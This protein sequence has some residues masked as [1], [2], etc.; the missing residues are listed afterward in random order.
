LFRKSL[1]DIHR[2]LNENKNVFKQSALSTE[3]LRA[4]YSLH[5][6]AESFLGYMQSN[7]KD[8]VFGDIDAASI[9]QKTFEFDD[10]IKNS[11]AYIRVSAIR[12]DKGKSVPQR[13]QGDEDLIDLGVVLVDLSESVENHAAD[14]RKESSRDLDVLITPMDTPNVEP[15]APQPCLE[16]SDPIAVDNASNA[17]S[18]AETKDSNVQIEIVRSGHDK[19]LRRHHSQLIPVTVSLQEINESTQRV[20]AANISSSLPS[21]NDK[22]VRVHN[23]SKDTLGGH[24]NL[25]SR[26]DDCQPR[27]SHSDET[28]EHP[29]TKIPNPQE[30][31]DSQ[32]NSQPKASSNTIP[33]NKDGMA[34]FPHTFE[35]WEALSAHWKGLT[36]FWVR[37]L[38]ANAALIDSQPFTVAL[39]KQVMDL[40]SAGANL[41]YAVVELQRLRASSER[42]VQRWFVETTAEL[43][44]ANERH[45]LMEAVLEEERASRCLI[46]EAMYKERELS[47][48]FRMRCEI[49]E[50]DYNLLAEKYDEEMDKRGKVIEKLKTADDYTEFVTKKWKHEKIRSGDYQ[51][52]WQAAEN[53]LRMAKEE[54]QA[55]K[56]KSA[57][58]QAKLKAV[59]VGLQELADPISA[60]EEISAQ[61]MQK[62]KSTTPESSAMKGKTGSRGT[63]DESST[64]KP[65]QRIEGH[66]STTTFKRPREIMRE[67]SSRE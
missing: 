35:R 22:R 53:D 32:Q 55:E 45:D 23:T 20:A 25:G 38:E 6:G 49:A 2:L 9:N 14:V 13:F 15:R 8:S 12:E 47:S 57:E 56:H 31:Q 44:R 51:E 43:E 5:D 42:K 50:N 48:E 46:D 30:H 29:L 62:L 33:A 1:S 67:R 59:F 52:S 37:Q 39:K 58:L 66:A 11:P 63:A 4:L 21:G 7:E 17:L 26:Q 24:K 19:K 36:T 41:F 54:L 34:T 64:R 28:T 18:D 27:S 61:P 3:S 16:Q 65:V 10:L 40:S 60:V